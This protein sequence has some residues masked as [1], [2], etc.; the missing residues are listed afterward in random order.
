[1]LIVD[2]YSRRD[3]INR[4]IKSISLNP[5]IGGI[6]I[7]LILF[8]LAYIRIKGIGIFKSLL[9]RLLTTI[10]A[11]AKKAASYSYS[12][13]YSRRGAYIIFT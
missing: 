10:T 8:R 12:R 4:D 6:I 7:Y 2:N 3:R 5:Y 13:R 1:M 9:V 11:L